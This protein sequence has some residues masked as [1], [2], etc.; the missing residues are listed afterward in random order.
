MTVRIPRW[1]QTLSGSTGCGA[2]S[3][4]HKDAVNSVKRIRDI[5]SCVMRSRRVSTSLR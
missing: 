2:R 1:V 5:D 3:S 4:R